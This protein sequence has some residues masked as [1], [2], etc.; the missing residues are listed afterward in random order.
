LVFLKM[1]FQNFHFLGMFGHRNSSL[2][3]KEGD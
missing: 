1:L 3:P 2:L